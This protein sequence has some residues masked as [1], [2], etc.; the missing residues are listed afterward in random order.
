M[1]YIQYANQGATRN[2]PLSPQLTQ[3]LGFLPD[4]GI[5][6]RVFSGGQPSAGSN[7]I[8]STRHDYGNAADVM[9]FQNGRQ[10]DWRN[11]ED[12]PIYQEIVKRGRAAGL[13][14]FGAGENYMTPGS[15][16]IGFGTPA[17]WGEEGR[18]ASAPQW[19]RDA[20]YGASAGQAPT[21]T[22]NTGVAM[23]DK[24]QQQPSSGEL[25]RDQRMVLG[26]AALRD[27]G[28]A[29]QGQNT[30]FFVD[31][32]SGFQQQ[33]QAEEDRRFRQ[34]QFDES[35]RRFGVE[36]AGSEA[37][38][39]LRRQQEERLLNETRQDLITTGLNGLAQIE[40]Q[41]RM[42]ASVAQAQGVPYQ[43]DPSLLRMEAAYAQM[44]N[45]AGFDLNAAVTPTPDVPAAVTPTAAPTAPE[46]QG[47]LR[48]VPGDLGI[49][50]EARQTFETI[51]LVDHHNIQQPTCYSD[52]TTSPHH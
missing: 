44:L 45:E 9:F 41:R 18:G 30:N 7:R 20:Y 8:G 12:V 33:A 6:A 19:L 51:R 50:D 22:Q 17:V 36:Q 43:D 37:E 4:L 39:L 35:A 32:M 14:G 27:A 49:P 34:T 48:L 13:T 31:T 29:L 10:L 15:M 38:R 26:F 5:T 42:A 2:Q 28:A 11:P 1:D 16:H 21:N 25:S 24:M 23:D 52:S 46:V 3:A 40:A 47:V